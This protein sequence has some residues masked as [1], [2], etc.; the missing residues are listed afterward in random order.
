MAAKDNKE[1]LEVFVRGGGGKFG[2]V[3]SNWPTPPNRSPHV[4][5]PKVRDYMRR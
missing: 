5:T 1:N 4:I 2:N 3:R